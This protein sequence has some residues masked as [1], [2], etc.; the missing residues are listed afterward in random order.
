MNQTYILSNVDVTELAMYLFVI[1]FFGLILYLRREDRREGYPLEE[2]TTGRL[3]KVEGLLWVAEPK[4]FR[5]PHGRGQKIVPNME[6]DLPVTKAKRMA[7][8][9]GAPIN[10]IGD[11][12][13]AGV[14]PGAF[15]ERSRAPDLTEHGAPRI[16]PMRVAKDFSIAANDP[17]PIGMQVFGVDAKLAGAVVDVWVDTGEHMI[18]YLEVETTAAHGS[19]RVIVPMPMLVV[20]RGKRTIRVD[21]VTAAQLAAAPMVEKA[22]QISLYEEDRISAYFG[23][24]YLYAMPTRT[25]AQL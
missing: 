19:K 9:P 11:P 15:A 18:R 13:S 16:A 8:W 4:V 24:G 25:E 5:L 22:D 21:A 23:A 7:V 14:G 6:R 10:P 17:N 2:D 12:L 20:N 3:E 1:F